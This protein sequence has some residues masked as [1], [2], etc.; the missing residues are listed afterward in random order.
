MP[1]PAPGTVRQ[2]AC[3]LTSSPGFILGG[4]AVKPEEAKAVRIE[5]AV[6]QVE[7]RLPA[8]Q[9]E[10]LERF[11][12]AYFADAS[13]AVTC[14]GRDLASRRVAATLVN[15]YP[16]VSPYRRRLLRHVSSGLLLFHFPS[17]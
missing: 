12:R 14:T 3:G 8:P 13:P 10:Q 17:A 16:A 9:A 15:S 5:E 11:V 6:T 1:G 4:M 7:E 2:Q